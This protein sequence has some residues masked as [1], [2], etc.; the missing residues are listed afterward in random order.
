MKYFQSIFIYMVGIN[1]VHNSEKWLNFLVINNYQTLLF[2]TRDLFLVINIHFLKRS[3]KQLENLLFATWG[4][5]TS[6]T[7]E[8]SRQPERWG[9]G[10]SGR[11][12]EV[13][14]RLRGVG[15]AEHHR[16]AARQHRGHR[17][18][19]GPGHGGLQQDQ[20]PPHRPRGTGDGGAQPQVGGQHQPRLIIYA[21]L[22]FTN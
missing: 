16:P 10:Q 2:A 11:S 8:G 3:L 18:D 21:Y 1:S 14:G 5:L 6:L 13:R 20:R 9:R 4:S 12:R 17:G 19:G 15:Q 22:H 7:F